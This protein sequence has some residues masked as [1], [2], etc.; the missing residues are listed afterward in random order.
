ML[1]VI[2][3]LHITRSAVAVA[4]H[5]ALGADR[6]LCDHDIEEVSAVP[7]AVASGYVGHRSC[8]Q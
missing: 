3:P 2:K 6:R 1:T 8:Y 4:V 7:L 5:D